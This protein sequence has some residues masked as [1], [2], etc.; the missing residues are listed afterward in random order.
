MDRMQ[1][2]GDN[3]MVWYP[4]ALTEYQ[5]IVHGYHTVGEIWV[6]GLG[7]VLLFWATESSVFGAV[8][9]RWEGSDCSAERERKCF[10]QTCV[11]DDRIVFVCELLYSHRICSIRRGLSV[12]DLVGLLVGD[13]VGLKDGDNVG[14]SVGDNVGARVGDSVGLMVGE[15]VGASVGENVG[16]SVG[17]NVGL[18]VGERVGLI[19][20]DN[21]GLSVGDRVG[22]RVGDKRVG[23]RVGDRV[24]LSVGDK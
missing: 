3:I 16:A 18:I 22:F 24:G 1:D 6:V 20:G 21:V 15:K 12:G 7:L 5:R 19:V 13:L 10:W 17:E 9:W 23:F 2:A 14:L 4:L 11:T 8:D